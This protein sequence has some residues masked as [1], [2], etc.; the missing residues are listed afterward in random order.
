MDEITRKAVVAIAASDNSAVR[1]IFSEKFELNYHPDN[2]GQAILWTLNA[3][4]FNVE[5]RE[6]IKLLVNFLKSKVKDDPG[7]QLI[8]AILE[9]NVQAA[10]RLLNG[11]VKFEG[12]EWSRESPIYCWIFGRTRSRKDML[13]LL[14]Q[15]GL[16][17][18]F[19]IKGRTFL[20]YF[21]G[22]CFLN[23]DDEDAVDIVKTLIDSGIS[24]NEF[25]GLDNDTPLTSC[26]SRVH[27]PLVTFLVKNGAD[28]NQ[29]SHF[30]TPLSLSVF[31]GNLELVDMLLH[32]GADINAKNAVGY[33][34]LYVACLRDQLQIID[35]LVRKGADITVTDKNEET[36]F[37]MV[38]GRRKYD[39]NYEGSA[40][41][42]IKKLAKLAHE[43]DRVY[44]KDMHLVRAD[45]WAQKH[46][47]NSTSELEKMTYTRF[48]ESHSY[49][50]LLKSSTKKLSN[51]T[52]NKEFIDHFEGNLHRFPYYASDLRVKLEEAVEVKNKTLV[53][54]EKLYSIFGDFFPD[55]VIRNLAS[56]LAPEDLP[57]D[58]N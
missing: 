47:E 45:P 21:L 17:V 10:E 30:D 34:A 11:G 22:S 41:V 57:D 25:D 53:V 27:V 36:P 26:I 18:G 28:V 29:V 3:A 13:K 40:V 35:Y 55:V 20:H 58:C 9:G 56:N 1:K 52:K 54:E 50:S 33:T 51:L 2:V 12:P 24:V 32:N 19:K 39:K 15:H 48:Y 23:K 5:N 43:N 38:M 8:I 44:Q 16:D 14:I 4:R 49:Y 7:K 46:F 42:M 37:A 31:L 6:P